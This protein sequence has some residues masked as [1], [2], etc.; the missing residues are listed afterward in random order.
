[1]QSRGVEVEEGQVLGVSYYEGTDGGGGPGE[2]QLSD[3]TDGGV[4]GGGTEASV[5]P[6]E[7]RPRRIGERG[8]RAKE[9]NLST[10]C[11]RLWIQGCAAGGAKQVPLAQ[12]DSGHR[13]AVCLVGGICR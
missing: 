8:R 4:G 13:P 3:E 7:G 5:R 12:K 9:D 2:A 1:M 11:T 10:G 6:V